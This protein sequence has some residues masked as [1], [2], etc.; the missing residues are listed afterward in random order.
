[1]NDYRWL[2][3][4]TRTKALELLASVPVGRLVFNHQAVPAIRPVNHLVEGESIVVRLSSG[5]AITAAAGRGGMMVAY[6]ADVIDTVTQLGWSVV[7][8]GTARLLSDEIATARYRSR[9]RSWISGA[10]DDVITISAEVVSGYRL[11][12]GDPAKYAQR[13]QQ[14]AAV[15]R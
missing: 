11:V 13:T 12:A 15:S 6:E 5:A 3:K 1:M 7:V 14:H 4:L 2:E 9:L 10:A 8:V